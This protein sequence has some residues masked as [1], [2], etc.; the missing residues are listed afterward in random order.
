V[1]N[2]GQSSMAA[3]RAAGEIALH[4]DAEVLAVLVTVAEVPCCGPSAE[5]C[6]LGDR[7]EA[8]DWATMYLARAGV[9]C[10]SERWRAAAHQVVDSVLRAADEY[11]AD[12]LVICRTRRSRLGGLL[13]R[14]LGLQVARRAARSVLLVPPFG[15]PDRPGGA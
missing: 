8:L 13:H 7:G 9:R 10:R 6:G 2:D 4:L 14:D 5:A 12:L 1:V 15:S 11:D 3:V